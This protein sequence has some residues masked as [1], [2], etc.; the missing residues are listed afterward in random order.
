MFIPH[1]GQIA[2][3]LYDL[4]RK[5]VAW[6]WSTSCDDA[7][8]R[9]KAALLSAPVLRALR[10]D[11]DAKQIFLTVDTSPIAAGWVVSQLDQNGVRKPAVYG[12][13]TLGRPQRN[14]DQ[15]KRELYGLKLALQA[16]KQ[17]I[18]GVHVI[19]ETDCKPVIGMIKNCNTADIHCQR[20]IGVIKQYDA[21]FVHIAGTENVMADM[22]SRA[23]YGGADSDEGASDD[24]SDASPDE[25]IISRPLG[26][27]AKLSASDTKLSPTCQGALVHAIAGSEWG[28]GRYRE[29][30]YEGKARDLCDLCVKRDAGEQLR[31]EDRHRIDRMFLEEG[32]FMAC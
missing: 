9:L 25:E 8:A 19:V 1:Y 27:D 6:D 14:Y 32:Y 20:W 28:S 18:L 16:E 5:G 23:A 7:M 31:R 2:G 10:Y 11:A 4:T 17:N 21:E 24:G 29:T 15:S 12:A 30:K 3:P 22:L 13:K 26:P